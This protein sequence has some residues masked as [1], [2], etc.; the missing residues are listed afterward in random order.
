AARPAVSPDGSYIAC[1]APK[2]SHDGKTAIAI[3]PIGG[4]EPANILELPEVTQARNFRWAADGKALIF[5]RKGE[6]ADNLWQQP[7]AG[8]EPTQLT[9]FTRL[10]IFRFA[11]ASDG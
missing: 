4:G 1:L 7:I 9:N 8:G 6:Q 11:P 5:S 2:A 3:V 10:R